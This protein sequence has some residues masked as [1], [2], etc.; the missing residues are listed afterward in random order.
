MNDRP[1]P[2]QRRQS[3]P[4]DRFPGFDVLSQAGHWDQ[5]TAGLVASRRRPRSESAFF[6]T[7]AIAATGVAM[8]VS[9]HAL[10]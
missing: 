4:G 1:G 6:A 9:T 7:M 8:I 2:Y 5:V 10:V 3:G